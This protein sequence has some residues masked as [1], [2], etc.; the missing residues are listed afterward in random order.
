MVG[1]EAIYRKYCGPDVV[2]GV[3]RCGGTAKRG[4]L[5]KTQARK[6]RREYELKYLKVFQVYQCEMCGN[7]HLATTDSK[8]NKN[9]ESK[10]KQR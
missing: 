6:H 8:W 9:K 3:L 2:D 10:W 5:T 7:W 4:F 1:M